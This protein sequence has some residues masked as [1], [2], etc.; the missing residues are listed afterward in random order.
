[1]LS[2]FTGKD[3]FM[4]REERRNFVRTHREAVF[5]YSR[6]NEGPALSIVYYV[7]DGDDILIS[8]MAARGKAKAVQC[9]PKVSL[10]VLDEQWPPTYLQVYCDATIDATVET[11]LEAV[12]DL[13]MRI[14]GLMAGRPLSES[15]RAMTRERA[16]EEH[17]VQLRLRPYATFESPPRHVRS[18]TDVEGLTHTLGRRLPW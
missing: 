16:L 15:V 7:M 6:E 13:L 1:M 12:T 8:T 10:C 3:Y 18:E 14:Q 9:N 4:K 2:G 11:N 5:G 17:R